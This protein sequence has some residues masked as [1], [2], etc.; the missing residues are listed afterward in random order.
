MRV[1]RVAVVVRPILRN[2]KLPKYTGDSFRI[3]RRAYQPTRNMRVER[4][5]YRKCS[6]HHHVVERDH[7]IHIFLKSPLSYCL[8]NSASHFPD[9]RRPLLLFQ[10]I[11]SHPWKRCRRPSRSRI[12]ST[13]K[14]I[15]PRRIR[16]QNTGQLLSC[17]PICVWIA[18]HEWHRTAFP[19]I[20]M[21]GAVLRPLPRPF[22]SYHH[23]HRPRPGLLLRAKAGGVKRR[24]KNP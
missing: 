1:S 22:T 15:R 2:I 17:R 3:R 13:S 5:R 6:S 19:P 11:S 21:S 10:R 16:V 20:D 12:S 9:S 18:R 14:H 4:P 8:P 23:I 7:P 24:R